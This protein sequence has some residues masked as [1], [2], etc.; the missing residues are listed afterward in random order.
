MCQL[1]ATTYHIIF[2]AKYG[3][4]PGPE[5][6]QKKYSSTQNLMLFH[7]IWA[8]A[9]FWSTAEKLEIKN[10]QL[11]YFLTNFHV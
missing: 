6:F 11:S 4:L 8:C 9:H 2:K 3:Y 10:G 5:I 7:P 1:H